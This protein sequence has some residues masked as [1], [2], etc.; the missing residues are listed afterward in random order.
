M[1]IG[2]MLG[3]DRGATRLDGVV[4]MARRAEAAGFDSVWMAHIRALDAVAA[5]TV[6][7]TQTSRIELGTA[8]TPI[9]PRHPMALAQAVLTANQAAGGRFTLGV[10]VSHKLVVEDML[11]LSYAR[12]AAQMRDYLEVLLPLLRG[13]SATVDNARYRVRNLGVDVPGGAPVPVIMAAL[14]PRMLTLAGHLTAGTST[15]MVGPHTLAAH[16]SPRLRAAAA[17]AGA[18]PPRIVAAVPVV[19]THDIEAT[20][21]KL[22][23][24]L[25]I[26][27]Q[28]PSY[29]AMLDHE[30]VTGPAD[31]ALIGNEQLIRDGIARYRDAGVTDFSAAIMA[32]DESTFERTFEFVAAR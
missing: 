5:L 20:R 4:E 15:W 31:L 19:L 23:A 28:L 1:R 12:P 2:V 14:G 22:A 26:Y 10:G 25:A 3:A 24:A 21:D 8:V 7:A 32:S 16:I 18:A 17:E 30:G 13:E 29:R 9:Q 11:G 6:A 27:G